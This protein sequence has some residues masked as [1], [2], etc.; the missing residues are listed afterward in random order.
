MRLLYIIMFI[1]EANMI[2]ILRY[3]LWP[4]SILY[5]LIIFIRNKAYDWGILKSHGFDFPTIVIGNLAIGGAGKSPMTEYLI[6]M[7][8][9]KNNLATLSRGYGR[10]TKG[11]LVVHQN[12]EAERVGDEPLQFKQK[13][14]D[15]SVA[16]CE[17]R[18]E[19]VKRLQSDHSLVILDDA[20][21]HRALQPG[22][23]IL[24]LEYKSLFKS[25]LVLPAG[26]LRDEFRQKKRADIIIISKSPQALSINEKQGA[27]EKLR[28]A[29][30]QTVLFSYLRYREVYWLNNNNEGR[31]T[32]KLE[33]Y[34]KTIKIN[35]KS[36]AL[37]LSGIADP[38]LFLVE[39]KS[40]V[41]EVIM[42]RFSDH[43]LFTLE[44]LKKIKST[45]DAVENPN[46]VIITTE[47]DSQRLRAKALN[48]IV[49]S[50]PIVVLP[51]ETAFNPSDEKVL[52]EKIENYLSCYGLSHSSITL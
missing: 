4:F 18:V 26:D 28:A 45:F 8:K 5:G 43:H 46:K 29:N 51:I 52:S 32:N 19:G 34:T 48:E 44:D 42:M 15:I 37:V 10:K 35:R 13:F 39:V 50:L 25:K 7:L 33:K 3:L 40:R 27:L 21:Q 22:L 41:K 30:H 9:N 17:D 6:R 36:T 24:L 20:F 1:F 31:E 11:F 14:P 47:K 2:K 16:V 12:D 23:S 49:E 38:S